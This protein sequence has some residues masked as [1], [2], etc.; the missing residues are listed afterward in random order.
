MN[1]ICF[2]LAFTIA[3]PNWYNISIFINSQYFL[4]KMTASEEISLDALIFSFQIK[5]F[6]G[7]AKEGL[8]NIMLSDTSYAI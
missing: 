8:S 4:L 7:H 3:E 6:R 2:E 5:F 1:L